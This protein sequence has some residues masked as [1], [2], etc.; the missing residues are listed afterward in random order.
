MFFP[1][2]EIDFGWRLSDES[3]TKVKI[4][5][6]FNVVH[7]TNKM[8]GSVS[9]SELKGKHCKFVQYRL[10]G[11]LSHLSSRMTGLSLDVR[12]KLHIIF[13]GEMFL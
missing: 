8:L 12:R 7:S 4:R 9:A 13:S 1:D 5:S 11:D 3:H 6:K 10:W 2:P